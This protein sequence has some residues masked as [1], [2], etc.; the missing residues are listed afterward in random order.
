MNAALLIAALSLA[1][2]AG[3]LYLIFALIAYS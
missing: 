2:W 3:M 1:A